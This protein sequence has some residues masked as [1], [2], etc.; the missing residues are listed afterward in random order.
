MNNELLFYKQPSFS[1]V[2][3][4]HYYVQYV[5]CFFPEYVKCLLLVINK[6]K[7]NIF[8]DSNGIIFNYLNKFLQE[9]LLLAFIISIALFCIKRPI[10]TE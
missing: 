4:V 5:H 7:E 9:P 8:F 2:N 6:S 3:T 1:E 10:Q